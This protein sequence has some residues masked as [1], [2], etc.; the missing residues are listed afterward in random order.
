M[1]N[2]FICYKCRCEVCGHDWV[3]RKYEMPKTC[4]S[5][6]CRSTQWNG[7]SEFV[8][9]SKTITD[10]S[11]GHTGLISPS[12]PVDMS[13]EHKFTDVAMNPAMD[14]FLAKLPQDEVVNQKEPEVAEDWEFSKKPTWWPDDGKAYRQQGRMVDKSWVFRNVEV[15]V[16]DL[17]RVIKVVK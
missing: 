10:L 17:E 7:G 11:T 9:G 12:E 1:I 4:A 2:E 14:V 3:T 6:K 16:D 5:Q 15:D 8:V 13:Q